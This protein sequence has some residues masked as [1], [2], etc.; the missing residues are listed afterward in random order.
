MLNN[1]SGNGIEINMDT[2][3]N[4]KEAAVT[5]KGS[6]TNITIIAKKLTVINGSGKSGSLPVIKVLNKGQLTLDQEVDVEGVTE[7]QKV[8]SVDGQ[9][10]S[11]TLKGKLKGFEG[12]K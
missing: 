3:R 4:P 12:G 11:V 2:G 6:G 9:G 1:S 8:I 10:F 5:V 7:M